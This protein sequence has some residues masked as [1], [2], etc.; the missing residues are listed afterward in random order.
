VALLALAVALGTA[1]AL[2]QTPA[3][4]PGLAPAPE[5]P[6]AAPPP[7]YTVSYQARIVPTQRIARVSLR[8]EQAQPLVKRLRFRID[9]ER[10][11]DFS[12]DGSHTVE[13]SQ[14]VWRPPPGGGTLRY[15]F[16]IDH[17]RDSASYDARCAENWAIFRGDDL[18]P[19]AS[20]LTEDGAESRSRLR[21]VVPEGWSAVATYPTAAD[22]SFVIDHPGRR[23]DRPTGWIAVGK[24]GVL[25][26]R[27]A[28]SRVAIAAPVGQGLRRHDMLA[29]LRW[30]LP[31]MRKVVGTL[32]DRLL[33]VGAGD[34][35]WRGG[36]SGPRSV[37]VH[38]SRPLITPDLTSPLLHELAHTVLAIRPG[39][40]G[41]W[42][43]EGL[44]EYYS[45]ELLRR[46][47]SVSRSRYEKA[48]RRLAARG[49]GAPLEVERADGPNTA[50]A[51]T[52]LHALD[53][54]LRRVSE[55][56]VSL[57]AVTAHLAGGRQEVTTERL[58]AL[59][60]ELAGRD[61]GAFFRAQIPKRRAR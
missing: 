47:R 25:R 56:A 53:D 50:R 60:E 2:A 6:G 58:Q 23:F 45:L 38:A 42:I 37:F 17:L 32:P 3:P 41:D 8:I 33:F 31:V 44:A 11:F 48:L 40:G 61:L 49:R 59:C 10:H 51:V 14:L 52:V 20:V 18:V 4:A 27:V 5:A 1:A 30:T 22:G 39:S 19:P 12:A 9:P 36:L 15:R 54:E 16:R 29:M 24:L 28:G 34:P 35:M 21:L 55:G 57:D 46:S 26:E 43:V 7:A 13:G